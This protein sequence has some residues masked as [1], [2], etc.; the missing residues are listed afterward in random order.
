MALKSRHYSV[1]AWLIPLLYA[2]AALVVGFTVP[3]LAYNVL[4]GLVSTVSVNAAIGIYSA[5]ASGMIALTGIVFSLTFVMVQ[6]SATAYSPRLVLWIARDPVVSHSLGVFT[7][8]FLYAIA[9]LA[10]VDRSGSGGVPL[11]GT[12]FVTA[13]LIVSVVMFIFLIQRVGMLQVNRML[14]FTA[15]QGREIIENLYPPLETLPSQTSTEITQAP[16]FQTLLHCGKPRIIQAVDIPALVG[17]ATRN[18][19]IIELVASVGDAALEGIPVLRVLGVGKP[20]PEDRLR[21]AIR[22]G[23]ERTFE[24]DPKYAIRLLVDIAIKAL[25]PAI[26]D[27]TTAVQALDQIED[28]LNR[29]GRRRLEIGSFCDAAGNLRLLINFPA[30]DD[31]LRLALDEI[32]LY[33]AS[34]VQVMR[35][36]KALVAELISILPEERHSALREW[37]RRLQS[38]IDHSFAN[39]QDKL[40]ASAEDRQG[41]G[42]TRRKWSNESPDVHGV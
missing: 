8:T 6:F 4:P 39:Q 37:Q 7:A 25:S 16:C 5:V 21:L 31:F 33:G 32:C 14:I 15:D 41:L 29:L 18:G 24:Q 27:P 40:D 35:R 30:W 3:R 10:W 12:V 20:I 36:M 2:T 42:S 26:N 19:C 34:S 38:T 17:I 13:L 22:L 11:S 1:A 9:A 23:A 28:L